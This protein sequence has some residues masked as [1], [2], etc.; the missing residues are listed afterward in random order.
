M[1]RIELTTRLEA[2]AEHIWQEL[3]KP[4]LLKHVAAGRLRF[5]PIEPPAF[6]EHWRDGDYRVALRGFGW[7]PLGEQ[8][9]SIRIRDD[10][11]TLH[12]H[13]SSRFFRRWEHRISLQPDGPDATR[14]T[15]RV[16]FDAG[17]LN[18]LLLPLVTDFFRHRQRRWRRLVENGFDYTRA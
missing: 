13:G 17:M 6:P 18:P 8:V 14:Y 15:D 1:P 11:R 16:E 9:I 10:E 12:D 2:P 3:Q 4:A 5:V 7:L